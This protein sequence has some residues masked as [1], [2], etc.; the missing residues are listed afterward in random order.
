MYGAFPSDASASNKLVS[1]ATADEK[2]SDE[3]Q[4]IFEVMGKMGAKN[5]LPFPYKRGNETINGITST[6]NA[7]GTVILNG[8]A[9]AATSFI[10]FERSENKYTLPEGN[11]TVS[12][13]AESGT[14]TGTVTHILRATESGSGVIKSDKNIGAEGTFNIPSEE[15]IGYQINIASGASFTNLKI[16][17]MIRLASD[18]DNTYQPYAKTNQELTAENMA[19][20]NEV[21]TIVNELGAKNLLPFDLATVKSL[22]TAGTWSGNTYTRNG[23]T[24]T[25]TFDNDGNLLYVEVNTA[26]SASNNA[27]FWLTDYEPK[28]N[29]IGKIL[30]GCHGGTWGTFWQSVYYVDNSDS[31]VGESGQYSDDL[32]IMDKDGATKIRLAI[33]VRNETTVS[34]IKF[35]PMIRLASITDNTYQPYAKTN[36]ELAQETNA[37]LDPILNKLGA[38]NLLRFDLDI[39]KAINPWGIWNGNSYTYYGVTYTINDDNSITVNGTNTGEQTSP[40]FLARVSDYPI[41]F[42]KG[43]YILSGAPEGGAANTYCMYLVSTTSDYYRDIGNGKKISIEANDSVFGVTLFVDKNIT[44]NNLKFYPM[45]RYASIADDTYAPYA[46]TNQQLTKETTGL[47]DNI[48]VLGA[49]NILPLTVKNIDSALKTIVSTNSGL[50][51]NNEITVNNV[52][53]S[54]LTDDDNNVIG[55]KL[56]G[57]ATADTYFRLYLVKHTNCFGVNNMNTYNHL[58]NDEYAIS[59]A[60]SD[61]ALFIQ[62]QSVI[63][64]TDSGVFIK[65]NNGTTIN[66]VVLY[67][68]IRLKSDV[69]DTFA[70]YAKSNKELTN[71]LAGLTLALIEG[72]APSTANA[73]V[74]ED[75]RTAL[76]LSSSPSWFEIL[77]AEFFNSTNNLWYQA[78]NDPHSTTAYVAK[79]SADGGRDFRVMVTNTAYTK[80]RAIVAYKP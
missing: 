44:V 23:V 16:A 77:S 27:Y 40:L 76:G 4:V 32:T 35:Y 13:V 10:F 56:N 51:A 2:I 55:V 49:K 64:S 31:Y 5:L 66:N 65:V 62:Y 45:F 54:V 36:R 60:N 59:G 21:D 53:L 34:N 38:K 7:D 8:T 24:F 79:V 3:S 17:P 78:S 43:D 69:D 47:I 42:S 63:S 11:Y 37:L 28:N 6:V 68:M 29:V 22:N 57:T 46:K 58:N 48:N 14:Y 52:T 74:T 61:D 70:P 50:D 1:D 72:D 30:N 18:T 12:A 33:F 25:P 71:D 41:T 20:T 9:T 15:Y 80:Y 73:Y 39:I 75:I 67:P 26:S 19:L